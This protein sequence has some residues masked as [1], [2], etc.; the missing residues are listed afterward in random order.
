MTSYV[1]SVA[2]SRER[3]SFTE[4]KQQHFFITHIKDILGWYTTDTANSHRSPQLV[5][6]K[7][8]SWQVYSVWPAAALPIPHLSCW[9]YCT[10]LAFLPALDSHMLQRALQSQSLSPALL[11]LGFVL[12]FSS[13][14]WHYNHLKVFVND[15][16]AS[17]H[18]KSHSGLR[19]ESEAS[20]V[21]LTGDW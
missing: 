3:L 4:K 11:P 5:Q 2:I 7:C 16:T 10:A 20:T 21:L 13:L 1:N 15:A 19:D 8:S 17:P 12:V 6:L 9:A 18:I 14:E